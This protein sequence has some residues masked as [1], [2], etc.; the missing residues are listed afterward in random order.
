MSIEPKPGHKPAFAGT[1]G[2][3][4]RVIFELDEAQLPLLEGVRERYSSTRAALIA[5]L[6]AEAQLSELRERAETAERRAEK[7]ESEKA[8]RTAKRQRDESDAKRAKGQLADAEERARALESELKE[9]RAQHAEVQK[10]ASREEEDYE[11]ALQELKEEASELSERAVDWLYCA[12]CRQWVAPE[13]WA[14][15]RIKGGGSYAYHRECG[16]HKPG[17]SPS[18]WLAQRA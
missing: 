1:S 6:E 11:E 13:G 4:R 12:R 16:D 5:A 14:W 17:L 8:L 3:R 18:S 10:E 9:A 2:L 15:Q 7:A